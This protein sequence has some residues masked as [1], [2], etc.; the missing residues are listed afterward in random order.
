M[1]MPTFN[2]K[3]TVTEQEMQKLENESSVRVGKIF[4]PGTY[5]LKIVEFRHNVSEKNPTGVASGDPT[6]LVYKV[7]LGGI[8]SR[9]ISTFILLPTASDV[10]AK[11]GMKNPRLMFIKCRE[12]FKALGADASVDNFKNLLRVVIGKPESLTGSEVKVVIGY[13]GN[14]L[15]YSADTKQYTIVDR[16]GKPLLPDR[17]YPDRDSAQVDAAELGIEIKAFPEVSRFIPSE[18]KEVETTSDWA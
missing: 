1:T 7:I 5:D 18:K 14:Y 8:D 9:T 4:Q 12:F 13:Q 2:F 17:F 6:W 15:Q 10:Y 11:P 3:S 16:R